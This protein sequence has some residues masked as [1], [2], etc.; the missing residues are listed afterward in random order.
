MTFSSFW[1]FL[2]SSHSRSK[3]LK[4]FTSASISL[5]FTRYVRSQTK[6]TE[7]KFISTRIVFIF[8]DFFLTFFLD[9]FNERKIVYFSNFS[10]NS[11]IC[12]YSLTLSSLRP[13]YF[14]VS[15]AFHPP[16]SLFHLVFAFFRKVFN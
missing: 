9:F 12:T 8:Q 15:L 10:L 13:G 7:F 11:T 3:S 2:N 14:E 4:F 16:F 5:N 1:F 6:L